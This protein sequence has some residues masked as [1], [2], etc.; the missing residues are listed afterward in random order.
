MASFDVFLPILLGFE[1]GYVDDPTDPGGERA[2]DARAQGEGIALPAWMREQPRA[3][4]VVSAPSPLA[5]VGCSVVQQ[6]G[7]DEGAG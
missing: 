2:R 1:G 7:S 5:G 4:A 6:N 3:T